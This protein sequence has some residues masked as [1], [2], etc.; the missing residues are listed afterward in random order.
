MVTVEF[1]V[2]SA[3]RENFGPRS[4]PGLTRFSALANTRPLDGLKQRACHLLRISALG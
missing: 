4:T 1:G 3:I 2:I